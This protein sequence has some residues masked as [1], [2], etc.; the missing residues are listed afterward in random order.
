M[1][2]WTVLDWVF[3]G[4][5]ALGAARGAMIGLSRQFFALATLA[6]AVGLSVH[7]QPL[8]AAR[9]AGGDEPG[10][11]IRVIAYAAVF[12]AVCATMLILRLVGRL[13]F[14]FSFSPPVERLGGAAVGLVTTALAIVAAVIGL[15]L[16]PHAGLRRVLSEDSRLGRRIVA[17]APRMYAELSERIPLPARSASE[18]HPASP[19]A[20]AVAP[21]DEVAPAPIPP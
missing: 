9:M 1:S 20:D 4:L 18:T 8:L 12:L 11:L 7:F 2:E 5:A 14:R 19:S 6:A 10:E 17:L 3:V 16:I 13:L 21:A 15:N